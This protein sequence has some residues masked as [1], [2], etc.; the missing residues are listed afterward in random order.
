MNPYAPTSLVY[1]ASDGRHRPASHPV[2]GGVAARPDSDP[3]KGAL[4]GWRIRALRI[5]R[6]MTQYDLA[7]AVGVTRPAVA[8][9]ETG[10]WHPTAEHEARLREV[11]RP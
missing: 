5:V 10:N 7:D 8:R 1:A 6:G 9:W 11:L 3:V 2:L 4:T